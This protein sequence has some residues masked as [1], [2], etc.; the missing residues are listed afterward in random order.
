MKIFF[1][2]STP[3][4]SDNLLLNEVSSEIKNIRYFLHLL[5]Q[6]INN[7][8]YDMVSVSSPFLTRKNNRDLVDRESQIFI[9]NLVE[10]YK[11]RK[12]MFL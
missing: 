9:L 10:R 12:G 11:K 3:K 8:C 4:N 5:Y 7:A 1:D 6:K 2:F